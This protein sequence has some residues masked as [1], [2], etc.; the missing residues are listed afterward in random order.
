MAT[1]NNTARTLMTVV[2]MDQ[3]PNIPDDKAIV[4]KFEDVVSRS[5][6]QNTLMQLMIDKDIKGLLEKHN[7]LRQ[8]IVDRTVLERTGSDVK[9]APITLND[10]E[11]MISR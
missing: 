10:L 7:N 1:Q 4:A 8:T 5:S 6:E 2:L 9:L 3:N 11:I